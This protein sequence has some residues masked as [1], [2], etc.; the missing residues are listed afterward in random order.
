MSNLHRIQ[1]IDAQIRA[2]RYPNSRSIAEHFEISLRQASRDIEYL[3]YSLNAPLKYSAYHNGYCYT[4]EAFTLPQFFIGEEEKMA[5]AYLAEQYRSLK[6][7]QAAR[8]AEL[9]SKMTGTRHRMGRIPEDVPVYDISPNIIQT[10]N[11]LKKA[12]ETHTAVK[13]VYIG[14]Y[15]SGTTRVV[16]PY[17]LYRSRVPEGL[18]LVKECLGLEEQA[19]NV[20]KA[21]IGN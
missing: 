12:I 20:I 11:H 4:S 10:Y 21:A 16:S 19:F 7:A 6:N 9:F 8:L 17:K 15:Q 18:S 3:R 13:L 1:W 2:K 5:L 14:P